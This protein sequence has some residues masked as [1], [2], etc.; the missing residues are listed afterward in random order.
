MPKAK[1]VP[2]GDRVPPL[3]VSSIPQQPTTPS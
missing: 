1:T 3:L 2:V